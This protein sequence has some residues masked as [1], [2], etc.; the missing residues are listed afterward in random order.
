MNDERAT[1]IDAALRIDTLLGL[2][3]DDPLALSYEEQVAAIEDA[4]SNGRI[5]ADRVTALRN[6]GAL[7]APED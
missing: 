4:A 2:G 6:L 5:D 7:P 3:V 1:G